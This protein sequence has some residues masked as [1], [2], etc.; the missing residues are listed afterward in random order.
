MSK[1]VWKQFTPGFSLRRAECDL[2]DFRV[3]REEECWWWGLNDC[4][5]SYGSEE[6]MEEAMAA[7]ENYY[8]YWKN[9]ED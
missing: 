5:H 1:L 6:T 4:E 3:W 9:K 2:G 7:A 8:D